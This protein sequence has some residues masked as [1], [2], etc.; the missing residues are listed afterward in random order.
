MSG[1]VDVNEVINQYKDEGELRLFFVF[2]GMVQGVGFRW[3]TQDLARR[4]GVS[5][6]VRNMSDG[7]VEAEMQGTGATI[8]SVLEGLRDQ[9]VD[10]RTKFPML[11]RM[12]LA[13]S[14]QTCERRAL[15]ELG[16]KPRFEVRA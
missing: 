14:V 16:D 1:A 11:R 13:F 5:G 6:W 9:F 3:T 4:A 8:C 15:L 7:T 10:A 2:C 12:G